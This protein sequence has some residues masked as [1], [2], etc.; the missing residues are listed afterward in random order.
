MARRVA[1]PR[2]RV[3]SVDVHPLPHARESIEKPSGNS[4]FRTLEIMLAFAQN[5][6]PHRTT[7]HALPQQL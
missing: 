3:R 2:S 6:P 5:Q 1:R 4:T 7:H